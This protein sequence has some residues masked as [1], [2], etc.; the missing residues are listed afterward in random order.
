MPSLSA[1]LLAVFMIKPP[2]TPPVGWGFTISR[3]FV[4]SAIGATLDSETA[5]KL[6]DAGAKKGL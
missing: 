2:S 4:I 1:F 3:K 6:V 5:D